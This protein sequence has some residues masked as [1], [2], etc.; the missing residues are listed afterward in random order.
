MLTRTT[1]NLC[2]LTMRKQSSFILRSLTFFY[3]CVIIS[4]YTTP[5]SQ[6][7]VFIPLQVNLLSWRCHLVLSNR[8]NCLFL[9]WLLAQVL[10][11]LMVWN[12]KCLLRSLEWSWDRSFHMKSAFCIIC[13]GRFLVQSFTIARHHHL[14][15]SIIL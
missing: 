2:G 9:I 7:S 15:W 8:M 13:K 4:L 14:C 3:R 12:E 11:S 10:I 5:L 1:L 6:K